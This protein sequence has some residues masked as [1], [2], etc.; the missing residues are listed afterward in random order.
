MANPL[1][2]HNLNE[3]TRLYLKPEGLGPKRSGLSFSLAGG[4]LSFN[5]ISL[6]LAS[7]GRRIYEGVFPL[8]G[9]DHLKT[10]LPENLRK[11]FDKRF[12]N[13]TSPRKPIRNLSFE[14][15]VLMGILNLTPDSFSDGG[16]YLTEGEVVTRAKTLFEEG[17]DIVDIGAESTRPGATLVRGD[18]E[19]K[20]LKPVLE[21]L[22]DLPGPVSIDTRKAEVMEKAL[23]A[24][25]LLINDV[26]ALTFDENSMTVAKTSPGIVLMHARGL[27]EQMQENP[28]YGDVLLE[29]FDYLEGRI[30]A[31]EKAGIPRE[32]LIVDP[33]IGFGKNLPHNLELLK[34]L[35]LFQALGVPVMA[36]LS[37]KRFIAEITGVENPKDRLAGSL[38][39]SLFAL[40]QGVQMVRCHDVAEMRNALDV[41]QTITSFD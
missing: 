36:G 28:E 13:L 19:L 9:L 10:Q 22:A 29:V 25:A 30:E 34:G 40:S 26:S 38:S 21:G 33:G 18:E 7:K 32:R 17:A 14:K 2:V 5:A 16:D 31:C 1:P 41:Y 15:P 37:R 20:R 12:S 8:T 6:V 39:A 3:D 24:G 27:P 4:P 23:G 11:N 35:S